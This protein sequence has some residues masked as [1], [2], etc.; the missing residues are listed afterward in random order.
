MKKG[1]I[2][3]I[4]AE[5]NSRFEI[6]KWEASETHYTVAFFRQNKDGDYYMETVGNRFFEDHDAWIVGKH[7]LNFLNDCKKELSMKNY[8]EQDGCHN[9][10]T[11]YTVSSYEKGIEKYLCKENVQIDGL[12]GAS[13]EKW[14]QGREVQPYGICDDFKKRLEAE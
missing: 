1:N 12:L 8:K 14:S 11:V 2:E 4:W 13:I 5:C 9:C 6:V 7:S 3:F 10:T